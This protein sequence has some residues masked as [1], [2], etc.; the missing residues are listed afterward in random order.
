MYYAAI[1][2]LPTYM[3]SKNRNE[4]FIYSSLLDYLVM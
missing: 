3:R 1:S 2:F 4:Y